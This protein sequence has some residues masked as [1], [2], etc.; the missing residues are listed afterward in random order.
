MTAKTKVAILGGGPAGLT[1]AFALSATPELRAK[2]AV[3]IYQSGWRVGGKCGQGRKGPANRIEIN[4]THYLF[5]AYDAAF[6]I[7]SQVFEELEATGDT[8]FGTYESQ[9]LS[10]STVAIKEFFN[11]NWDTWTLELPGSGKPPGARTASR[12]PLTL[13]S[14]IDGV[15]SSLIDLA[16][17]GSAGSLLGTQS[18]AASDAPH[19]WE[20]LGELIGRELGTLEHYVG[21]GA[22]HLVKTLASKLEAD[23]QTSQPVRDAIVWL[24]THFR[25]WAWSLLGSLS[26]SHIDAR[27]LLQLIDLGTTVMIGLIED[28]VLS[29]GGFDRIDQYD[30]REWLTRW[31]AAE[32]TVWSAPITT[33]YNAIAAYA[34]GDIDQP[35]MSAGM[36]LRGMLRLGLTYEGAF[37]FQLSY[38]VGDSIIAPMYQVLVNRGVT[39]MYF[40]RVRDLVPSVDGTTI[41]TIS[42]ERQVVLKSGDPASY[43]PFMLLPNG[44]P[45][46]PDAPLL[47]QLSMPATGANDLLSFYAPK[48]GEQY[49][50]K[51][52]TDFD[53]AV[54]A[55]PVATTRWYCARLIDQKDA[56][57]N[58]LNLGT[59]ETQSLR[60]WLFPTAEEMGWPYGQAVLSGYYQPLATWEDARQLIAAETWPADKTPGGIATL[61]GAF[62]GAPPQYPGPDDADYPAQRA[63][64]AVENAT[65]F[66]RSFVGSLW[67]DATHPSNPV[68]LDW[69]K[70]V[71]LEEG[72][73]G[74]QRLSTQSIRVNVGPVE[75]Y[76][77]IHKGTLQYRLRADESGY[78]NLAL[79]GD[80]IRNG[81]EIGSVE[82]AILG[83][84][85]AANA[86]MRLA[87]AT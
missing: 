78:A 19:W 57:R 3:T 39:F 74:E 64:A 5:G 9:F 48:V 47:D 60:L 30:L 44:R 1:A 7:A 59:T 17:T 82:G 79:A 29:A 69:S 67:P 85:Q 28:D 10:C 8:R 24:L 66:C 50:L 46:W 23:I 51:R 45:V 38:E 81:Y 26:K 16:S 21:V 71:A 62:E 70:L 65:R 52:G 31:G 20:R 4:G 68:G 11:G 43:Q 75:A 15:T 36:G 6:R 63:V 86:V 73:K 18:G 25:S 53:V 49:D 14:T 37:S 84:E 80:W 27:R 13:R 33:W 40:H 55:L 35:N 77:Q 34:D 32:T 83:G 61:F 72:V 2:Y 56:W 12:A 22:L 76:T 87:P 54:Y 41:D 58:M 42:V